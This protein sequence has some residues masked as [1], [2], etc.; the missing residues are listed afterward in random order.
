MDVVQSQTSGGSLQISVEVI[1]KIAKHAAL[2]VDGVEEITVGTSGAKSLL[3]KIA[4]QKPIRVELKEEVAELEVSMVVRYGTKV[5][6][7]SEKVQEAVKNAIQNM[8]GIIVTKVDIVI[9]GIA[10]VQ[11]APQPQENE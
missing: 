4:P 5:P 8:T 6:D 2:E 1:E 9:T 3:E 11:D 7:I 10:M